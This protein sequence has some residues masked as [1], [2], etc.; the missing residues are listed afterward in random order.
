[1]ATRVRPRRDRRGHRRLRRRHPR[2]AARPEGGRGRAAEGARRHVPASG[3]A[4]PPRRCSS[5][6][7]RSRS[8]RTPNEWGV[9]ASTARPAHRHAAGAGAQ[10][11]DRHRPDQGHR[12]P[13][14]EEQDRLD[15]G[16][17]AARRRRRRR[18]DADDGG[19][20]TLDGAKEIIVATGSTPR[21]VPG[22]DDRPHAHHHERRGHPPARRC[23]SRSSSWA[24]A[25]SGVEFASIFSASAARS[26]SSSCCRAWCPVEDE[27]VSAE[28]EK[29]FKKQRHHGAHRHEGDQ[30]EGGAPDGVDVEVQALGR[31]DR[32]ARRRRCC[33]SPRAAA[34]S[35]TGWAPRR[36]ASRMERGYIKVDELYRTNVPDI[37][38]IGDVITMGGPHSAAGARVVGG[39]HPG[40]RAPRRARRD[41]AQLRPR[42][43][44]HVLRSGDWQRRA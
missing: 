42:A 4:F 34:R 27:A 20:Q 28:L 33:S 9:A 5:T 24:A 25:P 19:T 11:Q 35:P 1:M 37:S 15:Q 43:R 21:S 2:R 32:A 8:R 10:G 12:V 23:R 3:A 17:R 38:A 41:A 16:H 44:L 39:G 14:Q 26:R 29:S 22:V 40:G 7:T 18:G 13:V 30:R 31:E 36:S 6:R